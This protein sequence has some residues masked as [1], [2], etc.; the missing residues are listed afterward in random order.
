MS[1]TTED[2]SQADSGKKIDVRRRQTTFPS[3]TF[4]GHPETTV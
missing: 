2:L 3:L 4:S 1:D